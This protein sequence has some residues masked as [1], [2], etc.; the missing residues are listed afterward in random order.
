MEVAS[1]LFSIHKLI[2]DIKLKISSMI[3]ISNAFFLDEDYKLAYQ[4]AQAA[5]DII[6]R[7]NPSSLSMAKLLT[8]AYNLKGLSLMIPNVAASGESGEAL[9]RK[10]SALTKA[11][12]AFEKGKAITQNPDSFDP[13][14][15]LNFEQ[16]LQKINAIRD[17][18]LSKLNQVGKTKTIASEESVVSNKDF[19]LTQFSI[20]KVIN[21]RIRKNKESSSITGSKPVRVGKT[22]PETRPK[23]KANQ[24]I[25]KPRQGSHKDFRPANRINR[26]R[27]GRDFNLTSGRNEVRR[28]TAHKTDAMSE[29]LHREDNL[30]ERKSSEHKRPKSTNSNLENHHEGLGNEQD[31][32]NKDNLSSKDNFPETPMSINP[33]TRWKE[34]RHNHN[35]N[36]RKVIAVSSGNQP[37]KLMVEKAVETDV[38]PNSGQSGDPSYDYLVERFLDLTKQKDILLAPEQQPSLKEKLSQQM[39]AILQ[40]LIQ[41]QTV[42]NQQSVPQ[43][44]PQPRTLNQNSFANQKPPQPHAGA[45]PKALQPKPVVVV[46]KSKPKVSRHHSPLQERNPARQDQERLLQQTR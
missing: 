11:A 44:S 19:S 38:I 41:Q 9:T 32:R 17:K 31:D 27:E 20:E 29:E 40:I 10:L 33:S 28:N 5:I 26:D 25:V 15:A 22:S 4:L 36:Q 45:S 12:T 24:L 35:N 43:Q 23:S 16:N 39:E 42:Q 2:P 3:S 8:K 46:S 13:Q 30:S 6:L 21:Y 18:I 1:R 7:E 37:R 14:A 34:G